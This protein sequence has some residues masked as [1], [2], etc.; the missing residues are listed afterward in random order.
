MVHRN[1]RKNLTRRGGRF[2]VWLAGLGWGVAAGVV[3]GSLVLAPA[4]DGGAHGAAA[5]SAQE[6]QH[7]S[8]RADRAEAEAAAANELLVAE[9]PTLV[10][11]T[12]TDSAVMLLRS[13]GVDPGQ[14]D[15]LLELLDAA[16]A[17]PAGTLTL[18]EKFTSSEGADQLGSIIANSLPA[19]TQLTVE[20]PSAAT[21]AGE[22]LADALTT[23]PDGT[24]RATPEDRALVLD[25]LTEA[26][27]VT[28]DSDVVAADAVIIALGDVTSEDREFA[29]EGFAATAVA[30]FATAL[31]ARGVPVVVAYE[32]AGA[33]QLEGALASR[34]DHSVATHDV[35][36]TEAGAILTVRAVRSELE[37]R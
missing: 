26:G 2:P 9:A 1:G 34:G 28:Q 16:G 21:H 36:D 8:A 18:T 10:E 33:N 6:T 25:A 17:D 27:Y 19:G 12:L 35:L 7:D 23:G 22:S 4:L 20:N 29:G 24:P 11:G 3:A 14:V 32:G 30:D 13:P 37:A 5:P 31:S 15:R